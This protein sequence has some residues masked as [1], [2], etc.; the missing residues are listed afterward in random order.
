MI[1][2]AATENLP[3]ILPLYDLY[4]K[5][6]Y[7]QGGTAPILPCLRGGRDNFIYFLA[8]GVG[9]DYCVKKKGS[10]CNTFHFMMFYALC[11]II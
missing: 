8:R 3:I 2:H 11:Y 9:H 4:N 1:I 5:L 10:D 7:S 6:I